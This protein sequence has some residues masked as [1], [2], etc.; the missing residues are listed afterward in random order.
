[1]TEPAR[2]SLGGLTKIRVKVH[3]HDDTRYIM[4]GPSIEYGDLESKVREKF[5]I[6]SQLRIKMEDDG[7]MITMADQDDL[8][9]LLGAVRN[10]ARKE[11][12]EMGKMEVS[13]LS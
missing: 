6:K 3:A 1:M 10:L 11:K 5:G 13:L 4:I 8:E 12:N 2:G 7:D 9:M